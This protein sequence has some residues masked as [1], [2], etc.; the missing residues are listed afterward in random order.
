MVTAI[1]VVAIALLGLVVVFW[2]IKARRG[3]VGAGTLGRGRRDPRLAVLD[4]VAV[5]ARRRLVLIKRDD[6]E[7]LLLIGGPSDVVVESRIGQGARAAPPVV[8]PNDTMPVRPAEPDDDETATVRHAPPARPAAPPPA[9]PAMPTAAAGPAIADPAD[10]LEGARG[11]VLGEP[12]PAQFPAERFQPAQRAEASGVQAG[13]PF[14]QADFDAV[15]DAEMARTLDRPALT[16]QQGAAV[17]AK[18]K[19]AAAAPRVEAP[20][21]E[22]AAPSSDKEGSLEE[23]MAK[24]LGDMTATRR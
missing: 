21:A 24:L 17:S 19:P 16:P 4:T 2:F 23:E 12:E 18:P 20:S 9:Q 3:S 13:N 14:D 11:R 5:D 15:L 6:V 1:L 8:R 22:S 10:I 7:H